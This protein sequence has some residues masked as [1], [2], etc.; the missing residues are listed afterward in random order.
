MHTE[1]PN[2]TL[3]N[4]YA[5]RA[6]EYEEIYHR[7]DPQR[8]KEQSKIQS[9]IKVAFRGAHVIEV[10]CGTGYWTQFASETAQSIVATDCNEEVL[11]IARHKQYSCP[12]SIEMADA[13]DLPF[14]PKTFT[15]GIANFWFS[16]IPKNRI[17]HF[18]EGFHKTLKA[19]SHIFMADNM[20]VAGLGGEL[21]TKPGD[22]NTYKLRTLKDGTQH[23]ILKNYF[24]REDLLKIFK[25]YDPTLTE[26]DIYIG[27]CFWWIQY[28]I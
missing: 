6:S 16:H 8:L 26:N 3:K 14:P 1:D 9:R 2:E 24:T 19:G 12:V 28:K 5:L 11:E 27:K 17:A 23:E 21:T 22:D 7:N 18:L 15:G 10:A 4:Y 25:R 20:N 13:Y